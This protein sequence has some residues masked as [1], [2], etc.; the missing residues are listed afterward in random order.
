MKLGEAL[1]LRA[2]QAKQLDDLRSRI[3]NNL[4]IQEGES[5]AEDPEALIEEFEG[6]SDAHAAL[7]SRITRTNITSTVGTGE[8]LLDLLHEREAL[9]RKRNLHEFAADQS[10]PDPSAYR[11][12]RTELRFVTVLD[13]QKH[14]VTVTELDEL[15][16]VLD[17]KIQEANWQIDLVE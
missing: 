12:M 14:R 16:R 15:I 17:A 4:L 7:V 6:V 1:S 9:R 11:Y 3:K 13:V 5:P 10:S 8:N 2:R